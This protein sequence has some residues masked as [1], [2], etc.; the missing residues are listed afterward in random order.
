MSGARALIDQARLW[1]DLM[2]LAAIT[3]PERP[4]TRRS[5][6]PRFLEGR[7][8]LRGRFEQAGLSGLSDVLRKQHLRFQERTL[9]R[10]L[11]W[12]EQ[13]DELVKF[14]FMFGHYR[15]VDHIQFFTEA[16]LRG[17]LA[18]YFPEVVITRGDPLYPHKLLPRLARRPVSLLYRL[19]VL[20]PTIFSRLFAEARVHA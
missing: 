6:S 14:E 11:A 9:K 19:G 8:W 10:V 12:A 13:F 2:A 4:Y 16:S 7:D 1:D 17:L 3:D 5:F 15:A 20:K 18:G